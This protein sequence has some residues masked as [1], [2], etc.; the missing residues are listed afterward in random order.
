MV[1]QRLQKEQVSVRLDSD[2][3]AVMKRRERIENTTMSHLINIACRKIFL[4]VTEQK[5]LTDQFQLHKAEMLRYRGLLEEQEIDPYS[6]ELS[7]QQTLLD[8][9]E[10]ER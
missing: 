6:F 8:L 10:D 2:V 1:R 7:Q 4:A 5:F 3:L 9:E